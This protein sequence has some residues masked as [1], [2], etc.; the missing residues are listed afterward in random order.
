MPVLATY[1]KIS[2]LEPLR[3]IHTENIS[4]NAMLKKKMSPCMLLENGIHFERD[5]G[6]K[7]QN[8]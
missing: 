7:I 1:N 6:K 3:K 5:S 2:D 8:F 4:K